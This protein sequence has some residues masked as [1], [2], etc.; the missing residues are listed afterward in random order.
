MKPSSRP[1]SGQKTTSDDLRRA[2]ILPPAMG[3][4]QPVEKMGESALAE[5]H[6]ACPVGASTAMPCDYT[7]KMLRP[8][9]AADS[10]AVALFRREAS[11]G[12]RVCHQHLVP[13]LDTHVAAAPY[14]LVM[15]FLEGETVESILAGESLP[16]VAIALWIV[17]QTAEALAALHDEGWIHSDVKPANIL[18]ATDGHAT[19]LD[20][21][22]LRSFEEG[23]ATTERPLMGTL[24]YLAPEVTSTHLPIDA[25]SDL[26]SLGIVL[27]E[28]LTGRHPGGQSALDLARQAPHLS[29]EVLKLVGDLLASD[30]L[31]RPQSAAA[32]VQRMVGL[33]IATLA[34]STE[35]ITAA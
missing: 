29:D 9:R 21:G 10:T 27:F 5:V 6:R 23:A 19:L 22:L 12:H 28:L 2:T 31:R 30:P 33:E 24:N 8:E 18:V 34:G 11:V 20:L 25:R 26:Y 17:R 1:A 35:S 14:Y 3:A 13:V 7:L 16:A 32:L 4:W 15:P